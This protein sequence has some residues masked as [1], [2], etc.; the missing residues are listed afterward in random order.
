M[1]VKKKY[2][3]VLNRNISDNVYG[4]DVHYLKGMGWD[5]EESGL[6]YVKEMGFFEI[7]HGHGV[8]SYLPYPD[9]FDLYEVTETT[10]REERKIN[11]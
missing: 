8:Y 4:L 9:A 10:T 2:R 5:L 7:C 11:K 6:E 3:I 1:G